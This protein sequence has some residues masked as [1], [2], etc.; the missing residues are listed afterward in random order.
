MASG[1]QCACL[2]QR[3]RGHRVER[4]RS[5]LCSI[6]KKTRAGAARRTHQ[7]AGTLGLALPTCAVYQPVAMV[8]IV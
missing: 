3:H 6:S 4:R 8:V 1:Q 7:A 5:E 2:G